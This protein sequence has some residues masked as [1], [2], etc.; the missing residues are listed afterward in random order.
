MI[1]DKA[2]EPPKKPSDVI[3]AGCAE[4]ITGWLDSV[5]P[6]DTLYHF[7]DT[8]G[9][10]GILRDHVIWASLATAL[11]DC[12]EV[13][14]GL[15]LAASVIEE[16]GKS[17]P[18]DVLRSALD[19]LRHPE[20]LR[21]EFRYVLRVCVASFCASAER[22]AHWMHYVWRGEFGKGIAFPVSEKI[23]HDTRPPAPASRRSRHPRR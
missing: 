17:E 1:S 14:Y 2:E 5:P 3:A 6:R 11:N 12:S 19:C 10:V 7:T 21:P 18:S 16:R 15:D 13:R 8:N 9:I 23:G 22:S 20:L 4:W